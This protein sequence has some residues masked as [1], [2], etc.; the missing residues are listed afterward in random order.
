VPLAAVM[1][2]AE[3]TGKPGFIV[4]G[5]LACAVAELIMGRRASSPYQQQMRAGHV[6]RRFELPVQRVMREG[7]DTMAPT[8]TI[9]DFLNEHLP[10]ARARSMPVVD[11]DG[12]YLGVV[13]LRDVQDVPRSDRATTTVGSLMANVP[14][15]EPVWPLRQALETMQAHDLQRISVVDEN[16]KFLGLLTLSDIAGFDELVGLHPRA[17]RDASATDTAAV[18]AASVVLRTPPEPELTDGNS[19]DPDRSSGG[20][21]G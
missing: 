4:P 3:T 13:R 1:F 11:G 19:R 6:E 16:G 9:D 17:D 18:D 12:S 8:A 20:E 2:V 15:A 10:S 21:E 5:V 14:T 7:A